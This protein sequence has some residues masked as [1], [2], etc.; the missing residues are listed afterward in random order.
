MALRGSGPNAPRIC[1]RD[2]LPCR[3]RFPVCRVYPHSLDRTFKLAALV[4]LG[5]ST[6][7]RRCPKF[8]EQMNLRSTAPLSQ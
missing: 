1:T 6:L 8:R 4:C 2:P 7:N 3:A 5:L